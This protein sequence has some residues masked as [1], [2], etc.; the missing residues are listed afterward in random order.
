[1]ACLEIRWRARKPAR[2]A[3]VRDAADSRMVNLCPSGSIVK[4]AGLSARMG[5]T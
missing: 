4:S 2:A 5:D 3:T 1:M